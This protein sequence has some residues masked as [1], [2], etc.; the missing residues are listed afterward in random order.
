M[1][2]LTAMGFLAVGFLGFFVKLIFMPITRYVY[3]LAAWPVPVYPV[4]VDTYKY[5][6]YLCAQIIVTTTSSS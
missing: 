3:G 2:R 6:T 5:M 1:A 4:F